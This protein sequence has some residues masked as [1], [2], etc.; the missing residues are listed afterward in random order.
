MSIYP[1]ECCCVAQKKKTMTT[2]KKSNE[3]KGHRL[4]LVYERARA[5]SFTFHLAN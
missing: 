1:L 4:E 3:K 2:T 5:R